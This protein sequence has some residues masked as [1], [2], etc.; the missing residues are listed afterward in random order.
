MQGSAR[1]L[2]RFIVKDKEVGSRCIDHTLY[3]I[4]ATTYVIQHT[5]FSGFSYPLR[6]SAKER[7][8]LYTVRSQKLGWRAVKAICSILVMHSHIHPI[9][10][11]TASANSISS[12]WRQIERWIREIEFLPVKHALCQARPFRISAVPEYAGNYKL[13]EDHY[14]P[15]G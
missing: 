2:R 14:R 1:D 8:I 10:H 9:Q 7:G 6:W 5:L 3:I 11:L 15:V 4:L 12:S 13:G